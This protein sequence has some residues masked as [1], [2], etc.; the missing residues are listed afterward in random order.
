ML[1]PSGQP[2]LGF[3]P[4]AGRESPWLLHSRSS[5]LAYLGRCCPRRSPHQAID[6]VSLL[7][8]CRSHMKCSGPGGCG[9]A[10]V[11]PHQGSTTVPTDVLQCRSSL[12]QHWRCTDS[13][14]P[15]ASTRAPGRTSRSVSVEQRRPPAAPFSGARR[16]V[17]AQLS[18]GAA[19]P[20]RSRVP[21]ARGWLVY[22][23][24][25]KSAGSAAGLLALGPARRALCT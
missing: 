12:L 23:A 20:G 16:E 5:G 7:L 17:V 4:L 14:H 22:L 2:V 21:L 3:P 6:G 15:A 11:H 24:G 25:G 1:T 13:R 9:V 19:Q 10:L 18:P 8:N